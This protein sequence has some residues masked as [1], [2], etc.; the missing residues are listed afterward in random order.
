MT[1]APGWFAKENQEQLARLIA[2][3]SVRTVAEIGSFMGCSAIW[4]ASQPGVEMVYC[5]DTWHEGATYESDNNLVGTLRRWEWPRDFFALFRDNIVQAGV[6][7]KVTAIRGH[8]RF[9]VGEVP[10]VDLIYVDGDHSYSGC[11]RDIELYLHKA[12]KVLC[13]DDYR[14]HKDID[15]SKCFGVIEAVTEL[16]PDAQHVGPFWWSVK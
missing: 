15:G 2:Q 11:K 8:S 1:W 3:H 14:H 12:R 16:L 9:V 10:E 4:F 6:W 7:S 5:I 13:G